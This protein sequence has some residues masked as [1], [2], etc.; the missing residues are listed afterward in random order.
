MRERGKELQVLGFWFLGGFLFVS[1]FVFGFFFL[2][3][4]K[5]QR[6]AGDFMYMKLH[7]KGGDRPQTQ[8]RGLD[9][10]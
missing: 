5:P 6:E 9:C 4:F 8:D 2:Y 1:L 3:R 7:R 10:R